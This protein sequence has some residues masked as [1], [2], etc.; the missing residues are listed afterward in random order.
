[1]RMKLTGRDILI[2][3]ASAAIT[4]GAFALA[5]TA[6]AGLV[7]ASV[8]SADAM[9]PSKTSFGEVRQVIK[10]PTATLEQL[11]LHIS[12]LNPGQSPHP[13]H[14]H[15]NEEL[16]LIDKGALETLSNGKW[17]RLGPGSVIF[18]STESWHGLRN[19]GDAPAQYFVVNW[20]TPA[21]DAIAAK[22]G[23]TE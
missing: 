9:K 12:T 2:A 11:E 6:T 13:P 23:H 21:T 5:Q 10:G 16:I 4:G 3:A 14:H 7:G 17:E 15:P 20:R 18:N 8:Y 22:N 19:V 1:M